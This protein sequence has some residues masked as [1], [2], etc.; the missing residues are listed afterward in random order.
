MKLKSVFTTLLS[1]CVFT[2]CP[3]KGSSAFLLPIANPGE[4]KLFYEPVFWN[5]QEIPKPILKEW[6]SPGVRIRSASGIACLSAGSDFVYG[7]SICF[8]DPQGQVDLEIQNILKFWNENP[9]GRTESE[10]FNFSELGNGR[11]KVELNRD[12]LS[13]CNEDWLILSG[14]PDLESS[15][16]KIQFPEANL[17]SIFSEQSLL[18]PHSPNAE[19]GFSILA[20]AGRMKIL[21]H[22]KNRMR[23][24][25]SLVLE[26]PGDA[27]ILSEFFLE[28]R[29]KNSEA[30]ALC[31]TRIPE[32]SE[33]FGGNNS[34]AGRFLEFQNPS[35]EP[36][37]FQDL[38]LT[39]NSKSFPIQ[40]GIGFLIPGETILR[41]ES[42]SILPGI[43]M[44]DFPWA[45]LKK[46]G[47]WILKSI[48]DQ[49]TVSNRERNFQEGDRFYSSVGNYYSVCAKEGL[50]ESSD[51]LCMSPGMAGSAKD[52]EEFS[53]CGI[54]NFQVEEA[55][56][57]GLSLNDKID[58]KQKFIDLEY[59]GNINCNPNVLSLEIGEKEYPIWLDPE[60][61]QPNSILTLGK[62]DW[63]QK[64]ILLSWNDLS[65]SVFGDRILL[66]DRLLKK[67]IVLSQERAETPILRKTNGSLLSLL[68][69]NGNWIPHPIVKS[70]SLS[71]PIQ[72]L[73]FMNPGLKSESE[74][75]YPNENAEL[76]ELSWMGS[77]DAG[78]AVSADRFLEL[79]SSKP[80]S[81]IVEI[82]SGTKSYSLLVSL[83]S[84]KNVFSASKLVCFPNVV[85]WILPELSVGS[86]GRIRILSLDKNF[87]EDELTW[88][89]QG[90]GINATSQKLR[91]S[92]SK[93]KT[94]AG[95]F[96]W[97]NSS[98]SDPTERKPSCSQTEASPGFEN[99]TSP[100]FWRE[101]QTTDSFSNPNLSWNLPRAA[102]IISSGIQ[103]LTFQ[104]SF[105]ESAIT[106]EFL[107]LWSF[108]K[109]KI[110]ESWNIPKNAL[111]YLIPN[112]GEDLVVLPGSSGILISSVYPNPVVSSNE[113]FTICNHGADPVDVRTLEIRDSSASDRLVEYSFRFGTAHPVGWETY[114]P[115]P[116]GWVFSDRFLK[117]E[118]CGYILSPSFKNESVPFQ[119]ANYRKIYTIETTTT[120]GNG[121][122]KNEGLDLFQEIQQSLVHVHSYGNQY[123]PFP[124]AVDADSGDLILLRENRFGDSIFDYEVRKKDLP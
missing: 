17:V 15:L 3:G 85:T 117:P 64:R 108:L 76:S 109:T 118:E 72:D 61:I 23:A 42:G 6:L 59:S 83:P 44:S 50:F 34:P 70:E 11:L 9:E 40:K 46:K 88:N 91:R 84:G 100:F 66:K 43:V 75:S 52:R 54:S 21:F 26:I 37:C 65:D 116:Y 121:I 87:V 92:A 38:S 95:T 123:S 68:Y 24:L 53:F 31:K 49:K 73:H 120:I 86:S 18:R 113:W 58:E 45:E 55:N 8:P 27:S 93:I 60:T 119:A 67:E 62:R 82:V 35:R 41:V 2:S 110:F 79:D 69:R 16:K 7:L 112:G 32:L 89:A 80:T 20:G 5:G 10:E 4:F 106:G 33:V 1:L 36:I 97:R 99:R 103:V 98:F 47:E 104:P 81:K 13:D 124:F 74:E 29:R 71:P 90:P 48:S 22:S 30:F 122:G 14:D 105:S 77:Y 28:I 78:I 115:D 25:N 101:T 94:L 57:T 114:N 102:G 111:R 56:L 63:I 39:V 51:R 96:L 107:S 12:L 19:V